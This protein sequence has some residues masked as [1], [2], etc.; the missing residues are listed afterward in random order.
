MYYILSIKLYTIYY[1][2]SSRNKVTCDID[3]R[4]HLRPAIL[5][6]RRY[7]LPGRHTSMAQKYVV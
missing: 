5:P 4:A 1:V 2:V 3:G 7:L 6:L